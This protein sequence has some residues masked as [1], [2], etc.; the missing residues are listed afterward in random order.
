MKTLIR[1]IIPKSLL[2]LYHYF[3]ATLAAIV[4]NFPSR[5]LKVIGVTGTTGK[6]TACNLIAAL[7]EEEGY[8]V[9][10]TTTANFKIGKREWINTTKQTMQGRF[11]LQKLLW[12]MVKAGCQYAVIETSSEGLAQGRHLFIDYDVAVFTNLS[13]EH[14]ESHGGFEK[15]KEAKGKLFKSLSRS[16]KT[17]TVIVANLDDQNVEYF[18]GFAADK[19]YG[20]TI[21]SKFKIQNSKLIKNL[22]IVVAH[23]IQVNALGTKFYINSQEFNLNLLGKFNVYNAL[24]AICVGLSQ[25]ISLEKIR[26]ALRKFKSMPGRMEKIE[27][28]QDF[29][30]FVDYAHEPRGLESIYQTL[31]EI[32]KPESRIISVLGSCGGGRDKAKRPILGKL[33]AKYTDFVIITNED[34]YDEDPWQIINDVAK[35]TLQE[36]GREENKNFWKILD[37]REAIKKAISLA[38]KNDIV[39]LTGKGSE[40][41][42]MSKNGKKIPWDERRVV[43]EILKEILKE[44]KFMT[45]RR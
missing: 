10:L 12:E 8:K 45:Y 32:K 35:G 13:P 44:K 20:Y 11:R 9:G 19:K 14:I 21:N 18:L 26:Q 39:I 24:A 3:L 15:Y 16:K 23:D 41:C 30:V 33:A 4:Y 22:Q 43:R 34:P 1:K 5:K 38:T 28:G 31:K 29:L 7:L 25:N 6:T 40:Q 2:K 27:A 42:I 37:R 17:P 36:S